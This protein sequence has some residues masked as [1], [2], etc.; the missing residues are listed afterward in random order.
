MEEFLPTIGGPP[1]HGD[2]WSRP[3]QPEGDGLAVTVDNYALHR[4]TRIDDG[5]VRASYR[6]T[7]KPGRR[8]IW[9]GHALLD[10]STRASLVVPEDHPLW[11]NSDQGPMHTR[12]PWY[13]RPTCRGSASPTVPR[14]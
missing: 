9:A 6:L 2:V 13:G 7:A 14:T 10:L 11:V 1:D 12:W 5:G 4:A 8:F 3:W